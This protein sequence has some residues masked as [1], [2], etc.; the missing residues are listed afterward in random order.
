MCIQKDFSGTY[1]EVSEI[2]LK[3]PYHVVSVKIKTKLIPSLAWGGG[4]N[5]GQA[6]WNSY[7]SVLLGAF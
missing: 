5:K 2:D 1:Q 6:I 3:V 7:N 4:E